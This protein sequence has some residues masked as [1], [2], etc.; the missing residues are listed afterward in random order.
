VGSVTFR[1]VR[2]GYWIS[3]DRR[4]AIVEMM[5]GTADHQ[6]ALFWTAV[7]VGLPHEGLNIDDPRIDTATFW[8]A[9]EIAVHFTMGE[10]ARDV[11]AA[12]QRG[13]RT[14]HPIESLRSRKGRS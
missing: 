3:N 2:E 10:L 11:D 4:L 9:D 8:G 13:S 1:C 7:G 12:I 14:A 5:A 6:W